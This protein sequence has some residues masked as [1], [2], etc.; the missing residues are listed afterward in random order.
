MLI[1]QKHVIE[2]YWSIQWLVTSCVLHGI[3]AQLTNQKSQ[4][5]RKWHLFKDKWQILLSH[6]C[7]VLHHTMQSKSVKSKLSV[8]NQIKLFLHI[9]KKMQH[10]YE[11]IHPLYLQ[12]TDTCARNQQAVGRYQKYFLLQSYS[13]N[14]DV[15]N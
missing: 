5:T 12:N 15:N 1:I 11:T 8:T 7:T 2:Q 9:N 14:V 10:Q 4:N 6:T 13:T 3:I